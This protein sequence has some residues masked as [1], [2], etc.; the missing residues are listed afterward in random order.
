MKG[1][2]LKGAATESE[3]AH[4]VAL[5]AWCA[6]CQLHGPDAAFRWAETGEL[7]GKTEMALSPLKKAEP[8]SK[9]AWL[10]AIPNGGSRGSD[11]GA[12]IRGAALK[13]EGVKRG[14]ADLFLPVSAW[15]HEGEPPEPIVHAGLFI[16]MK[17]PAERPKT[18]KKVAGGMSAEQ[19]EFKAH[20]ESQGYLHA[21]CYDWETAARSL[22]WY[23][24]RT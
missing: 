16:E 4:Q 24:E 17:R 18:D 11:K 5:M 23:L 22:V 14:V 6:V 13:A 10:F 19:L 12:M 7:A 3:H 8:W 21:V 1:I 20:V 15:N 9:L 2:K